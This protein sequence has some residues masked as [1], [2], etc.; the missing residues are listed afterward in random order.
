M[1]NCYSGVWMTDRRTPG[2]QETAAHVT[3]EDLVPHETR[4]LHD[5]L[6][7]Q[8]LEVVGRLAGGMA[9]DFNNLLTTIDGNAQLAMMELTPGDRLEEYLADIRS[10]VTRATE[11]TRQMLAFGRKQILEPKVLDLNQLVQGVLRMLMR[12]L[13]EDVEIQVELETGIG[14]IFADPAQVE[15]ALVHLAINARDA[16][17][18]GGK[19]RVYTSEVNVDA[20]KLAGYDHAEAGCFICLG[21]QDTGVGMDHEESDRVFDPFFSTKRRADT[22]GLGLA[23]VYGVVSQHGGFVELESSPGQGS[24]FQ[25]HFPCFM[26]FSDTDDERNA[27]S[28][29]LA[30]GGESILL[31]E[32]DQAVRKMTSR[33][34]RRQGFRVVEAEDGASA[35]G[36]FAG[37][38][39]V[40]LLLTDVIMPGM[41]GHEV[42]EGLTAKRPRMRVLFMSGYPEDVI[43]RHGVLDRGMNF[44]SKP[45]TP[46]SL[47]RQVRRILDE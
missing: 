18:D 8:R 17:P 12:L 44:I 24:R 40:D 10:A 42:A 35:L 37:N 15:Q 43:A 36:L 38:Q 2:D 19:L 11:L 14:A 7:S 39:E 3:G 32:D 27:V 28:A 33:I 13:G 29:P 1:L 6:H 34:L 30:K 20:Q 46:N 4:A 31:V 26:G 5:K 21:M 41:T 23:S 47:T 45:F 16:M 22:S 9:H 25:L